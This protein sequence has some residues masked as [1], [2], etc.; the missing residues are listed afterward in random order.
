[1]WQFDSPS[2]GSQDVMRVD[3]G[4]FRALD[5]SVVRACDR[6]LHQPEGP[7]TAAASR[8]PLEGLA[9]SRT[10]AA[11]E[12]SDFSPGGE[13]VGSPPSGHPATTARAGAVAAEPDEPCL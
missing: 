4:T 8:P 3:G 9:V 1:M 5:R 6:A 11:C 10:G 7:V 12:A 2:G 13:V